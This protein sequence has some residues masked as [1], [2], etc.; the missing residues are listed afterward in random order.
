MANAIASIS[1]LGADEARVIKELKFT[2]QCR[3][4]KKTY[5]YNFSD[6]PQF[7]SMRP[8]TEIFVWAVYKRRNSVGHVTRLSVRDY[9]WNFLR[10]LG[11]QNMAVSRSKCNSQLIF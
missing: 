4:T 5:N 9:Y 7:E 3:N 10:F 11:S 2:I 6:R 1:K 8:I